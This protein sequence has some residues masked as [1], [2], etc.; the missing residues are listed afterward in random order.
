MAATSSR[1]GK[2]RSSA[3]KSK[4]TAVKPASP[5]FVGLL[6]LNCW[7]LAQFGVKSFDDLRAELNHPE[8]VG[9]DDEGR[10]RFLQPLLKLTQRSSELS[11]EK[12]EEFDAAISAITEELNA[13]RERSNKSKIVW[14]YYQYLALL[15]TEVYLDRYFTEPDELVTG[16]NNEVVG[17]N[18]RGSASLTE[19]SGAASDTANKLAFWM[20]TGSGKTFI[21]H[22]NILQYRR[23]MELHKRA[24]AWK[25]TILITPNKSLTKQHLEELKENGIAAS[26]FGDSNGGASPLEVRVLEV[27]RL[28]EKNGDRL[29]DVRDFAGNNLLLVDEGHRGTSGGDG[30]TWLELRNA[31]SR[32]GFTFEYS[33]TFGQA[34]QG[35][36]ELTDTYSKAVLIDYS[37]RRFRG[38]GYGKDF[39]VLNLGR[40]ANSDDPNNRHDYLT[41]ALLSFA[42]QRAIFEATPVAASIFHVEAP[43]WVFVGNTV[44]VSKGTENSDIVTILQF[45]DRFL[46]N[47]AESIA[48][49]KKLL[50]S[51]IPAADGS[52]LFIDQ[53]S[54]LNGL[55]KTAEEIWDL[56]MDRVFAGGAGGRLQ[57]DRFVGKEVDGEFALRA[58]LNPIAFG[59]ITVGAKSGLETKCSDVKL[60]VIEKH[61]DKGIFGELEKRTELTVLVGAR[62]FIEGWNSYRV[63]TMGLMN[64]GKSEGSQ[65]IQLFGR[66]VRL[67]GYRKLLKRST[68]LDADPD[69][70]PP[71]HLGALETLGIFGI[72]AKYMTQFE[73]FLAIEGVTSISAKKPIRIPTKQ[74]TLLHKLKII[75]LNSKFAAGPPG[76][77]FKKS[78]PR[79]DLALPDPNKKSHKTHLSEKAVVANFYPAISV[80]AGKQGTGA[81]V[82]QAL[83]TAKLTTTH[84]AF[85]NFDELV[86][87]L[88]KARSNRWPNMTISRRAVA[89]LLSRDDWYTLEVPPQR[90]SFQL[91]AGET[92]EGRVQL[93]MRI[94]RSLLAKYADRYF[95]MQRGEWERAGLE[96]QELTASHSNFVIGQSGQNADFHEI[97]VSESEVQLI[98]ELEGLASRLSVQNY[99]QPVAAAPALEAFASPRHLY[100]PLLHLNPSLAGAD[101]VEISPTPLNDGERKFI[102]DLD[103]FLVANPGFL[104]TQAIYVLRNRAR[105]GGVGFFDAGDYYPDFIIWLVDGVSQRII[106]ADPK[107]LLQMDASHPKVQF[108]RGVKNIQTQLGDAT[109]ELESFLISVSPRDAVK[110]IWQQSETQLSDLHVLFQNE[111][112]DYVRTLLTKR[113]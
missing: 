85:L 91:A 31:L 20:A 18:K 70:L 92:I 57:I 66:G 8:L 79:F 101:K 67:R 19:L 11:D 30:G 15:F 9:M 42:Q 95:K 90:M 77:A 55:N 22:A 86:F 113:T 36:S 7:V 27:T 69:T 25:R 65:I 59:V 61:I 88:E 84:V 56:V 64:V 112:P 38:D 82:S 94:A 4:G 3:P 40:V 34:V 13:A 39:R 17:V 14:Q 29:V 43:L 107:G 10:H 33:A 68:R 105:G 74:Q 5:R 26:E 41:G 58:G 73:E 28:A 45:F 87:G 50:E 89:A 60:N 32:K 62:K 108:A 16:V 110:A 24:H 98:A 99:S 44:K 76:T 51:G 102:R 12:L 104:G 37:Y 48:L 35:D 1:A 21:M 52:N 109:V 2:N 83:H 63:A 71:P 111:D 93:W 103:G 23:Q 80:I 81:Q 49:I 106:F 100:E 96:Y 75:G 47:K 54:Y 97:R 78:G 53:F 46:S 72:N 6:A